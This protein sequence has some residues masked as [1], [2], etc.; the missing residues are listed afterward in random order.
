[1][2]HSYL[3][4]LIFSEK[5]TKE[6]KKAIENFCN[7]RGVTGVSFEETKSNNENSFKYLLTTTP[8]NT[9]FAKNFLLTINDQ[10]KGIHSINLSSKLTSCKELMRGEFKETPKPFSE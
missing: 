5:I 7:Q 1:M 8:Q 2:T 9:D 10:E 3:F 6:D 4:E